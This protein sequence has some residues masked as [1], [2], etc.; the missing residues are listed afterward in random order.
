MNCDEYKFRGVDVK[1]FRDLDWDW[2]D[3][4]KVAFEKVGFIHVGDQENINLNSVKPSPRTFSRNMARSD[5]SIVLIT[6]INPIW[7][8]KILMFFMGLRNR[9]IFE[10]VTKFDNGMYMNT[11]TLQEKYLTSCSDRIHRFS[12]DSKLSALEILKIH[13][14]KVK[15]FEARNN[16][17]AIAVM[18]VDGINKFSN[19]QREIQHH[20]LRQ[21]GWVTEEYMMNIAPTKSEGEENIY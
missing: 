6:Q 13:Q 11:T 16:C 15:D 5:G 3:A 19:E 21:I 10:F 14:E 1:K 8:W 9:K 20:H 17:R 12:V 18:T 2:Y 7:I 4:T